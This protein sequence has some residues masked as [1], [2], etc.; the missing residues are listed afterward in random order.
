[1]ALRL[2]SN[3]TARHT[4]QLR[5]LRNSGRHRKSLRWPPPL[6]TQETMES[7]NGKIKTT[8]LTLLRFCKSHRM[9]DRDEH[10]VGVLGA[11]NSPRHATTGFSPYML[12][13]GAETSIPLSFLYPVFL[14]MCFF[15][16]F[17]ATGTT[18][19]GISRTRA[20]PAVSSAHDPN[21]HWNSSRTRDTSKE[22]QS[23][24]I[25]LRLGVRS[26]DDWT[27]ILDPAQPVVFPEL[28]N[29]E[30]LFSDQEEILPE[31]L[32]RNLLP[33]LTGTFAPLL[34]NSSLTD[35]LGHFS[36]FSS[37]T[38]KTYCRNRVPRRN[39]PRNNLWHR[40]EPRTGEV[41]QDADH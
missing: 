32:I 3:L 12:Q 34:S 21:L 28:D 35:T 4:S 13:L 10:I 8:R 6:L 25:P 9:L 30:P 11:Y 16:R 24:W 38:G 20:Y 26:R 39:W 1:M 27:A 40:T 7:L 14:Y 37:Q 36:L 23:L 33:T 15:E 18:A 29:L 19:R 41:N 17:F 5:L 31:E 2:G 22:I